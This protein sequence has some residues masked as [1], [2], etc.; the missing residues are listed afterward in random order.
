MS[1][2]LLKPTSL[3]I[4]HTSLLTTAHAQGHTVTTITIGAY[5][6][7]PLP[8]HPSLRLLEGY[9]HPEPLH[10]WARTLLTQTQMGDTV[11]LA[12]SEFLQ[13]CF[14]RS[15][16]RNVLTLPTPRDADG[17]PL[18]HAISDALL[19]TLRSKARVLPYLLKTGQDLLDSAMPET[20][21]HKP[22]VIVSWLSTLLE[23]N[24]PTVTADYIAIID[25]E[26]L[27]TPEEIEEGQ[28]VLLTI[29]L[30]LDPQTRIV[31]TVML[32]RA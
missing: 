21:T 19:A 22:G 6:D 25:P 28:S 24:Q 14:A 1:L 3:T 30:N 5:P 15:E 11:L 10:A 23:S 2:F 13:A 29:A 17:L 18:F 31:D 27:T 7:T 8:N 20:Q 16:G 4:A 32:L 26:T 12:E 9:F